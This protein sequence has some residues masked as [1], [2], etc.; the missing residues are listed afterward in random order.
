MR[1]VLLPAK[2]RRPVRVTINWKSGSVGWAGLAAYVVAWD[3]YISRVLQGE[4]LTSGFKRG[5]SHRYLRGAVY[6]AWG[7]T[8]LHL[9]G[10]LPERLDPYLWVARA[11]PVNEN[12][13][14]LRESCEVVVAIG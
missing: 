8:T 12:N 13:T 6:G 9:F 7:I 5:R 1:S 14:L 4:T 10:C 3:Y 11:L 2:R